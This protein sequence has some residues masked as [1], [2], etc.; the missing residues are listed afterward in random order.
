MAVAYWNYQM[1][2]LWTMLALRR[3]SC[4]S[5]VVELMPRNHEIKFHVQVFK[6]KSLVFGPSCSPLG[7]IEAQMFSFWKEALGS[8]PAFS[9][10]YFSPW[11]IGGGENWEP[12][13]LKLFWGLN[14]QS[15]GQK[16]VC[17]CF[18][19]KILQEKKNHRLVLSKQIWNIVFQNRRNKK[20]LVSDNRFK[21]CRPLNLLKTIYF[22]IFNIFDGSIPRPRL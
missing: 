5:T 19:V 1:N 6:F 11:V 8:I 17:D 21:K 18:P 7:R 12:A 10:C 15:L 14:K 13:D 9:K 4:C 2:E 3:V 16:T 22:N 20:N